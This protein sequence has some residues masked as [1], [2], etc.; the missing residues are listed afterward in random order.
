MS[1]VVIFNI[2]Y[3]Q[4]SNILSLPSIPARVSFVL[5]DVTLG[6]LSLNM[7]KT[8]PTSIPLVVAFTSILFVTVTT[9]MGHN[10]LNAIK[11]AKTFRELFTTKSIERLTNVLPYNI[12][13][14]V[15][16]CKKF[17][18]FEFPADVMQLPVDFLHHLHIVVSSLEKI[19]RDICS[20]LAEHLQGAAENLHGAAENWQ[21][22]QKM[23]RWCRKY[24]K[25]LQKIS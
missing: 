20:S 24:A 11:V 21:V 8:L 25:K 17:L 3:C 13:N 16:L 2:Q 10:S 15:K 19:C 9:L 18:Q 1:R 23:C 4:C 5:Q 7:F 22:R 14:I 6:S 12:T